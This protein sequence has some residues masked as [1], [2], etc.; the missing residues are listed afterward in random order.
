MRT[1]KPGPASHS[2]WPLASLPRISGLREEGDGER[3]DIRE[4]D[5]EE[6]VKVGAH[7]TLHTFSSRGNSKSSQQRLHLGHRLSVEMPTA[8]RSCPGAG[9]RWRVEPETPLALS[10]SSPPNGSA[11]Q[12]QAPGASSSHRLVFPAGKGAGAT[13][14]GPWV[15]ELRTLPSLKGPQDTP[16]SASLNHDFEEG[17]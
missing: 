6:G 14:R 12:H 2:G 8:Y 13:V 3:G 5:V 16:R 9:Q 17:L 15:G 11:L 4:E 1:D 10:A 7:S